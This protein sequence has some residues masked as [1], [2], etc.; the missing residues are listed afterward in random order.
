[1]MENLQKRGEVLA[2]QRLAGVQSEIKSVLADELPSD[3]RITETPDGLQMEARRLK[4]RL[5][6]HSSLRDIGFLMRGVR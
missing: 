5:L 2:R 4:Q 6:E 1:M 3:I